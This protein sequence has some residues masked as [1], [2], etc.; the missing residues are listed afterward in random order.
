MADETVISMLPTVRNS[1]GAMSRDEAI[2]YAMHPPAPDKERGGRGGDPLAGVLRASSS[3]PAIAQSVPVHSMQA[4][5]G[6]LAYHRKEKQ[7]VT[8]CAATEKPDVV[9]VKWADGETSRVKIA[10]LT[11]L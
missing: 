5:I 10:N 8:I 7:E 3:T 4:A 2:A 6:K 9:V 1:F 11:L